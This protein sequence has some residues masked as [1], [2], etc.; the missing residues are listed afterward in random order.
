[1]RWRGSAGDVADGS[2]TVWQAEETEVTD[3]SRLMSI[4]MVNAIAEGWPL[5]RYKAGISR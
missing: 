3:E 1:M 2:G 4:P 5:G